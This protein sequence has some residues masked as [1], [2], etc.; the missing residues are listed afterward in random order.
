MSVLSACVY[1]A[2]GR[3]KRAKDAPLELESGMT[4]SYH[5]GSGNLTQVLYKII[6][7]S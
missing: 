3:Q 2:L 4:V 7:Y 6:K 5:Q 1:R